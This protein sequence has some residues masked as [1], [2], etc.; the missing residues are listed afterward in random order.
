MFPL[1]TSMAPARSARA[2]QT[3]LRGTLNVLV[4]LAEFSDQPLATPASHFEDLFFSSNVIPTGSVKEYYQEV[5]NGQITIQ[6]DVIG[7]FM[8]PQT[9]AAYAH[10]KSGMGSA[11]PNAQTMARDAIMALPPGLNLSDYDNDKDG[12]IDAFIVVHAGTGAE[13]T[14]NP[15]QIWSHKWVLDGGAYTPPGN[16]VNVYSYLTVP[17]DYKLGVCA[18]EL[19]HLLFGFPDLYDTSY[20]SEGIG[21]WCLMSGG[22]WNNGGD[23]PAH[24]SAWCKANQGWVTIDIPKTNQT[25]VRISDVK[26]GYTIKRLWKNG[27]PG[28]EYFLLENR[29][30]DKYDSYLPAGGLLIWHIDDAMP[31]NANARHYKVGLLQA[32][33]NQELERNKNPGDAGDP[34]PGAKGNTH[35]DQSSNPNALSYGG[36]DS[37]VRVTNIRQNGAD[38]VCD[39]SVI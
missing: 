27:L 24:P 20:R 10:L 3:P 15:A 14:N 39:I 33:G 5:T 28:N 26:T 35:F 22:S 11:K 19:G 38:I 18:H 37:S 13:V 12:Y 32:D 29:Q 16:V 25:A 6:G 1:G 4:V 34:F 30:Q 17:E 9:L 8:M 36:L 7:P 21:A 31:D 23:T 2:Q